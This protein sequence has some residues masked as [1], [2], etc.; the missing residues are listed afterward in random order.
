MLVIGSREFPI[1]GV[2]SDVGGIDY[3]IQNL[4][5]KMQKHGLDYSFYVFSR[6]VPRKGLKE[7]LS[8][9]I[10]II[11]TPFVRFRLLRLIISDF[12]AFFYSLFMIRRWKIDIIH[13]HETIAGFFFSIIAKIY[14]TPLVG[15]I[16]TFGSKQPEWP[17]IGRILLKKTEEITIRS[18]DVVILLC[19]EAR[20]DVI[21]QYGCPPKKIKVIPNAVD[22]ERFT[23]VITTQYSSLKDKELLITFI[24]R[25]TESKGL[26]Y[27]IEAIKHIKTSND[28]L[29]AFNVIIAGDGPIKTE[30]EDLVRKSGLTDLVSFPGH[31]I[32]IESVLA[33]TDVFIL[34]SLYEGFPLSLLEAMASGCAVIGSDAGCIPDII[35]NSNTGFIVKRGDSRALAERIKLLLCNKEL[36][37]KLGKNGREH[38]RKKYRWANIVRSISHIYKRIYLS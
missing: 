4:L 13:V 25:L 36:R 37:L 22:F 18:A 32:E 30:L 11:H 23:N 35:T 1:R 27:L 17:N 7:Y 6:F 8:N 33:I 16:H 38:I 28:E 26:P 9:R 14:K 10:K 21:S 3:Y 15:Q 24:G 2:H 20:N 31:I 34:P 5:I 12:F 19:S 29:A